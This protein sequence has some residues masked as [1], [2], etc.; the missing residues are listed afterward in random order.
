MFASSKIFYLVL[1]PKSTITQKTGAFG[2]HV[3]FCDKLYWMYVKSMLDKFRA[4]NLHS[5]QLH[6]NM[7]KK[8]LF[9]NVKVV[10]HGPYE[11]YA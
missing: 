4:S 2:L 5:N 8:N 11:E 10:H 7:N 6:N 1:Q 3:T 9:L